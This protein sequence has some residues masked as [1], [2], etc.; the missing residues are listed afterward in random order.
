[1]QEC[2]DKPKPDSSQSSPGSVDQTQQLGADVV[3]QS[4]EVVGGLLKRD[5]LKSVAFYGRSNNDTYVT[6]TLNMH[7]GSG[8]LKIDLH[9][10]LLL[11][12]CRNNE[13][14]ISVLG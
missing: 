3:L 12:F 7:F 6:Y 10:L 13:T 11:T 5:N 4:L 9:F 1:M 14:H 8:Q 2:C